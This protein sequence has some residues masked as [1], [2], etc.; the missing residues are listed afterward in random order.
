MVSDANA[1]GAPNWND[2][3]TYTVATTATTQP[4][5]ST[6][7]YQGTTLVLS[8]NAGFYASYAWPGAQTVPLESNVW[9][10]GGASCAAKLYSMDG[11]S[12]T[13][14]ATFAYSVGA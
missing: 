11:G 8:T 12:Q 7:C 2:S 4:Y 1:N 3:V 13:I 9:R 14:L 5:V 6:Q 10:S